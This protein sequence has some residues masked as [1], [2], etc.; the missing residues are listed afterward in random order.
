MRVKFLGRRK[1]VSRGGCSRCGHRQVTSSRY[2]YIDRIFTPNGM[3]TFVV[4][5]VYDVSQNEGN[6][7][8][9]LTYMDGGQE[10]HCFEVA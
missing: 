7:L 1:T 6:F 10:K 2:M 8:L 4:D 3:K 9:G 5:H